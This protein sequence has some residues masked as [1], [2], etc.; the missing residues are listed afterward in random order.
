MLSFSRLRQ[1]VSRTDRHLPFRHGS[2]SAGAF[3]GYAE[4]V[5]A[6]SG[7]PRHRASTDPSATARGRMRWAPWV[8]D[9]LDAVAGAKTTIIFLNT[10][11]HAALF[12]QAL[13]LTNGRD[14]P[15]GVHH[16]AL[17]RDARHKVEATMA[18]GTLRAVMARP[19]SHAAASVLSRSVWVFP[20]HRIPYGR[21]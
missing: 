4:V 17:A 13:W 18:A 20:E 12:F 2:T 16:G 1:I 7:L 15:I 9:A 21:S 6:D 14:L 8:P 10:R 11:A 3:N 19:V 5:E